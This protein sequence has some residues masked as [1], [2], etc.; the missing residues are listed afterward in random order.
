MLTGSQRLGRS[1]RRCGWICALEL[2]L[3][4]LGL[5]LT[6]CPAIETRCRLVDGEGADY[7]RVASNATDALAIT[8]DFITLEALVR[9]NASVLRGILGILVFGNR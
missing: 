3:V 7:V 1:P 2:L 6:T 9:R 4:A 5:L 8:G